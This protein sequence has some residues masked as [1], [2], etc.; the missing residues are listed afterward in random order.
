MIIGRTCLRREALPF[1]SPSPSRSLL[2]ALVVHVVPVVVFLVFRPFQ[3]FRPFRA[4]RCCSR[5]RLIAT[6]PDN[7]VVR[8]PCLPSISCLPFY[9]LPPPCLIFLYTFFDFSQFSML[10]F[11]NFIFFIYFSRYIIGLCRYFFVPLHPNSTALVALD[12]DMPRRFSLLP[13]LSLAQRQ[14][15]KYSRITDYQHD[16]RSPMSI[17]N[18]ILCRIG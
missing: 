12:P 16:V 15:L 4:F 6:V 18:Q 2:F 1:L 14:E 5:C 9:P 8:P 10:I 7:F 13:S 11:L 17:L 3:A